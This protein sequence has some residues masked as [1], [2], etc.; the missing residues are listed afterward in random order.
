VNRFRAFL[1]ATFPPDRVRR[2]SATG[3][4]AW[5]RAAVKKVDQQA[6]KDRRRASNTDDDGA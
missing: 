3:E 4:Q 1:R 5:L 6:L 2:P